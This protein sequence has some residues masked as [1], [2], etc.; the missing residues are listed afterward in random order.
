MTALPLSKIVSDLGANILRLALGDTRA[1]SQCRFV[2]ELADRF[3]VF[4]DVRRSLLGRQIDALQ[5]VARRQP[6]ANIEVAQASAVGFDVPRQRAQRGHRGGVGTRVEDEGADVAMQAVHVQVRAGLDL[7][8]RGAG[9]AAFEIEA[10]AAPGLAVTGFEIDAQRH[11]NAL[12][13][14]FAYALDQRQ[15]VRMIDMEQRAFADRPFEN[16]ALLVRAIENDVLCRHAKR[17]CLLVLE[18]RHH[19]GPGAFLVEDRTDGAV[20]V[21]LV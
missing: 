10:E 20:V 13:A 6:A 4:L 16:R 14:F 15:F 3:G 11:R 2:D 21:G 1:P 12:A 7:V 19:F 5:G 18:A 8:D 17:A 9:R